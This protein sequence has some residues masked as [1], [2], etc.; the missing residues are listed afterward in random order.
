MSKTES[1][2]NAPPEQLYFE[3]LVYSINFYSKIITGFS[4]LQ[5][6]LT[7]LPF[8]YSRYSETL[9]DSRGLLINTVNSAYGY[10]GH[11]GEKLTFDTESICKRILVSFDPKLGVSHR[12]TSYTLELTQLIGNLQF[13]YPDLVEITNRD[14]CV[15]WPDKTHKIFYIDKYGF[16]Q[17]KSVPVP[18]ELYYL[19]E[20]TELGLYKWIA[21][22]Y[23]Y[24][25]VILVKRPYSSI[26]LGEQKDLPDEISTTVKRLFTGLFTYVSSVPALLSDNQCFLNELSPLSSVNLDVIKLLEYVCISECKI[27]KLLI[28]QGKVNTFNKNNSSITKSEIAVNITNV[29]RWIEQNTKFNFKEYKL[30]IDFTGA[31]S[32]DK[33][34]LLDQYKEE[35]GDLTNYGW[36]LWM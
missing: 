10:K 25:E 11:I 35:F 12:A 29:C 7:N 2:V 28:H 26:K 1:K 20:T 16:A 34:N 31:T 32:I 24:E 8:A 27:P 22:S 17:A 14:I 5:S 18:R 19:K 9:T 4:E 13:F 15:Y 3:L 30:E 36:G 23:D 33:S 6:T 21:N